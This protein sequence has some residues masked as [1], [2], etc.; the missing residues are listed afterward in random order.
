MA[1]KVKSS[2][3]N[4]PVSGIV[5]G[6]K[7]IGNGRSVECR[8]EEC[9]V[10]CRFHV[11]DNE[12]LDAM[13]SKMFGVATGL[14]LKSGCKKAIYAAQILRGYNSLGNPHGDPFAEINFDDEEG[15]LTLSFGK[16][17]FVVYR[18]MPKIVASMN[19]GLRNPYIVNP[20]MDRKIRRLILK[21]FDESYEQIVKNTIALERKRSK[22]R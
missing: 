13:P 7:I 2:G 11:L 5:H 14:M 16:N 10:D 21:E 12:R 22:Q 15:I 20:E 8:C 1:K 17:S 19:I 4:K 9:L 6:M 18:A 3:A